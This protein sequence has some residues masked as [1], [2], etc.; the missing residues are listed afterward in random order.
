MELSKE[1]LIEMITN[2]VMSV[3]SNDKALFS[4]V[5]NLLPDALII[6]NVE[7]LPDI[8]RKKYNFFKLEK[9]QSIDDVERFEKIFVETLSLTELADI[10]MGRD[11]G[12]TQKAVVGALLKG[13]KIAILES[14]LPHKK[15]AYKSDRTFYQIYEEYVRKLKGTKIQFITGKS[16]YNMYAANAMPDPD[17]PEGIIT[18]S[19]AR[20][21]A[22]N[23]VNDEIKIKKGTVITP[24]AFDIFN[25]VGKKVVIE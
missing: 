8:E 10:A 22:M 16:F 11:A 12:C 23:C 5:K 1:Q 24:S 19:V 17:I 9:C 21:M 4:N 18:E 3:L 13:K 25:S 6:G 7:N 14:A 20:V 2:E 15:Y